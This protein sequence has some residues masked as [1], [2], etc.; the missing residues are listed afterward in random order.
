MFDR[1]NGVELEE[2]EQE[3]DEEDCPR[4]SSS[5]GNPDDP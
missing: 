2:L 3:E 1:G 4:L 5:E